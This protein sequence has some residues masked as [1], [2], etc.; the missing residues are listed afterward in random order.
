MRIFF[1]AMGT[2][3]FIGC[4]WLFYQYLNIASSAEKQVLAD[5]Q[6]LQQ[7]FK[8]SATFTQPQH[9]NKIHL[10]TQLIQQSLDLEN[11]FIRHY[12]SLFVKEG[13]RSCLESLLWYKNYQP[14]IEKEIWLA[15][16]KVCIN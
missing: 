9:L 8:V 1:I 2:V 16:G 4:G 11:R 7:S 10:E 14:E 5:I 13:N 6:W 12:R 15:E 3:F